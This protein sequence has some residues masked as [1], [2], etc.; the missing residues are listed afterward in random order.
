MKVVLGP[1]ITETQ[2]GQREGVIIILNMS[3]LT[4]VVLIFLNIFL[5]TV[6]AL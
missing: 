3:R 5:R 1:H 6:P 2:K 4:S